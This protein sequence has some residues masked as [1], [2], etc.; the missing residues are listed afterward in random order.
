MY[1]I[2]ELFSTRQYAMYAPP[3][4][5]SW[6]QLLGFSCCLFHAGFLLGSLFS[7]QDGGHMFL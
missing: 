7:P 2:K 1:A 6:F 4:A 3:P 5:G